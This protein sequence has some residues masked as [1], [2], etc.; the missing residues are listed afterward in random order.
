M[1]FIFLANRSV[2][3]LM[4]RWLLLGVVEKARL[5]YLDCVSV[6]WECKSSALFGCCQVKDE[7]FFWFTSKFFLSALQI[8]TGF[9]SAVGLFPSFGIA[10]IRLFITPCQGPFKRFSCGIIWRKLTHCKSVYLWGKGTKIN[11]GINYRSVKAFIKIVLFQYLLL[12]CE[13]VC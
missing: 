4:R 10:K 7:I 12:F 5:L 8:K 1:R 6:E 11:W 3:E 9:E 13:I 2:K